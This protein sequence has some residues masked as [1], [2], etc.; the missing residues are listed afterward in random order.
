MGCVAPVTLSKPVHY[1]WNGFKG[2]N[3]ISVLHARDSLDEI[4]LE[5]E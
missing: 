5:W 2:R 1:S 4:R 3:S